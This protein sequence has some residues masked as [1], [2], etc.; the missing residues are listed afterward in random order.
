MGHPKRLLQEPAARA[1]EELFQH[2]RRCALSLQGISGYRSY[3]RQKELYQTGSSS[4]V[5]PPGCSEHQT[6][7]ALDV[8]CPAADWALTEDFARTA[9]YRFL[10]DFGPAYGFILRYPLRKENMTGYAWEP[11]HIRFVSKGPALYISNA[12]LTLEE[13][14]L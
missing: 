11:W 4:Y 10:K 9:E 3:A 5:A 8:S 1:A 6:G 13:F 7:L 14:L 2:A 12:D